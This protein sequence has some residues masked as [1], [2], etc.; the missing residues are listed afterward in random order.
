MIEGKISQRAEIQP[1][2]SSIYMS[3]KKYVHVISL[4]HFSG[5]ITLHS[6]IKFNKQKKQ[7]SQQAILASY[8]VTHTNL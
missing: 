8:P 5:P 3:L 4:P 7:S 2:D 6:G 1:V